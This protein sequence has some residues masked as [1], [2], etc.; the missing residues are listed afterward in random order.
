[1][2]YTYIYICGDLSIIFPMSYSIYLRGP[3]GVEG[4]GAEAPADL[5]DAD[6]LVVLAWGICF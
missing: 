4:R 3:V 2:G 6:V 1:M 5:E